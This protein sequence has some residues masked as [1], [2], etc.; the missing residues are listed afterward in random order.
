MNRSTIQ[1][2]L[3]SG[4]LVGTSALS[5]QTST[6][7]KPAASPKAP[8][9]ATP[10]NPVDSGITASTDPSKVVLDINGEKMTAGQFNDLLKSFPPQVQ[11][12]ASGPKR[13][14]FA[15]QF[16]QLKIAAQE[17][18]HENLQD[19]PAIKEQLAIQRDNVLAGALYQKMLAD[20]NV[21][22]ADIQKYYDAHKSE[23]ETVKA[24]HILIRFKG[25]AVPVGKDKKDLTDEEAL[26]KAKEVQKRLLAGEDFAKVQKEETDDT[27]GP[28]P[29][30]S[31]GQMVKEFDAAAFS[32]P[33]GK[34]SDPVKTQFGYHIIKVI[35]RDSKTL[36]QAKP[37]FIAKLRQE[38]V[39][40]EIDALREKASVT[41]DEN[42]FKAPGPATK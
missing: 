38:E 28:L 3:F 11:Q 4:V 22:D 29:P 14:E 39:K 37:E 33:I 34:I 8:A 40:K 19:S 7:T 36:E 6:P 24:E 9:A 1:T 32:L 17:A 30:F 41:M 26:A 15:E 18:Q 2:L 13:H 5:G 10:G 27:S 20:V 23:F 35:S 31:H 42:F 12:Q 16:I 21:S 25:S